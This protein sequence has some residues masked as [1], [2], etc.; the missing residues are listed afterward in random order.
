MQLIGRGY[1]AEI[2]YRF[3][4][5]GK[6]NDN[7]VK[8]EGN[9]QDY[10]MRIYDPRLVRFLSVD[11]L[12][13]E[14][15]WNSTYAFAENEPIANIDLDGAEKKP[16]K[17][18]GSLPILGRIESYKTAQGSDVRCYTV[19]ED[20]AKF[21]VTEITVYEQS[22]DNLSRVHHSNI[23]YFIQDKSLVAD[24]N[25]P[26]NSGTS[27]QNA[28]TNWHFYYSTNNSLSTQGRVG[29]EG[30]NMLGAMTFGAAAGATAA[31]AAPT[32]LS[33]SQ[34]YLSSAATY[35]APKPGFNPAGGAWDL[36]NQKVF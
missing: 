25:T 9:Q 16:Y 11:P 8:G 6:E 19:G 3:G 35:L 17:P 24:R 12:T 36:I 31:F 33:M 2:G 23:Y 5:N 21:R 4:F 18:I 27:F 30:A 14:Y 26:T 22:V 13:K 29:E 10:G 32:L 15:P 20:G 28:G 7:D 34:P 1:Q